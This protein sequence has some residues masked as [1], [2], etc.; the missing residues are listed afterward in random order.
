MKGMPNPFSS[1]VATWAHIAFCA[2]VFI[3]LAAP[4][5]AVIPVSFSSSTFI[6]YPLPGY[7]M[8]W[9]D[10][11]AHSERWISAM[12]YSVFFGL[13]SSLLAVILGTLAAIGLSRPEMPFRKTITALMLS[14]IVVPVVII[15][16]GMYLVWV[17]VGLYGTALGVILGH[18]VV[19]TPF[20]LITVTASLEHFDWTYVKAASGLGASPFRILR[21]VILPLILP[22]ILSGGVVAFATSLDEIVVTIFIGSSDLRT[23]PLEMFA[24]IRENISPEI[25]AA[26]TIMTIVASILLLSVEFIRRRGERLR[27][28]EAVANQPEIDSSL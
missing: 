10:R 20:V 13:V 23:I 9:Y 16:L 2:A 27:G 18:T 15:A 26:A 5:I 19:I 4:I 28:R 1:R 17:R 25:T 3:F 14:P 12:G 11:L 7:S 24:G 21:S 8:Q 22:G 6:Y